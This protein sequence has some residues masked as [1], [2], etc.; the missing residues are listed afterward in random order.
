[1]NIKLKK[2]IEEN[3]LI[4][5][6]KSTNVYEIEGAGLF[7]LI[8]AKD[9]KLIDKEFVFKLS[10]EDK[11]AIENGDVT[12]ALFQFGGKYYYTPINKEKYI[13]TKKLG[14]SL[15][16]FKYLGKA[17]Q[18]LDLDFCH[19]GV[20]TEYE[21]MNGTHLAKDW[22]KKAKFLGQKS[23]GICDE[24]TLGGTLPFQTACKEKEIK[25][26]LGETVT[27]QYDNEE[28]FK[29]KLYV[30]NT[31]GWRNLLRINKAINVDNDGFID[32]NEFLKYGEGLILVFFRESVIVSVD[33]IQGRK[34]IKSYK[35]HFDDVYY[36]IDSVRYLDASYD[37]RQ[38]N[39][40]S[41]YFNEYSDLLEPVLINDSYYV[42]KEEF[43]TKRII[44]EID[45][46]A[47]P[48][49]ND[50]HYKTLDE[51]VEILND[52]F[53]PEKTFLNG[54]TYEDIL[55]LM[56]LNTQNIADKCNFTI[57]TGHHKL[58]RFESG[59][60]NLELFFELLE[61][62]LQKKVVEKNKNLDAYIKRLDIETDVIVNAGFVDYFL[63]LWDIVKW[64]K[65]SGIYV[66][67]ARGS[68]GG[69]LIAFLL[70]VITVDPIEHDL[71][72]ERFINK[73][74]VSGE[75][76]KAADALPDIDVDF[77]SF[78]RDDIKR[79]LEQKYG[80]DYVCSIGSYTRLKLKGSI[81]D[82]CRVDGMSFTF[83]NFITSRIKDKNNIQFEWQDI[84]KFAQEDK[85]LY[86]FIQKNMGLVNNMKFTINQA[87]TTSIHASAVIIVPKEDSE[88]NPMTIYDWM[89][90][91]KIVEKGVEF[92]VSEWEGKY[93]DKA[94]FLKEDILALSQL[95]KFKNILRLIKK[96]HG[97]DIVLEDIDM[98]V[99]GVYKIFQRGFNEEIFQFNSHGLKKYSRLIKPDCLEDLIAMNALFRPGPMKSN[100][101][102]D[103]ALIKHGKK[104]PEFDYMLKDVTKNTH[105][106]YVYQEQI[107]KAV[108]VLGNLTLTE[109]DEIRTVMKKF[110]KKKML[111]YEEKFIAGAKQNGCKPEEAANIWRKL[112]RFSG[113]GFN[114]SHSAAYAIMAYWCQWLKFHYPSE[115]YTVCFNFIRKDRGELEVPQ[116]I[117]EIRKRKIDLTIE[118]PNVNKSLNEFTLEGNNI[119]WSL[120]KI[121]GLGPSGTLNILKE[122][123]EN[124][125]FA[126]LEDFIERMKGKRVNAEKL[127]VAGAFDQL[128]NIK[129]LRDRK[130]LLERFASKAK[131]DLPE[132]YSKPKYNKSYNWVLL[133]RE[134]T[135]FGDINYESIV[136]KKNERLA[137]YYMEPNVFLDGDR[138][139][140]KALIAGKLVELYRRQSRRGEFAQLSLL[141]NNEI[142]Y[143]TMWSDVWEKNATR[144]DEIKKSGGLIAISGKVKFDDYKGV[145][146]LFTD[147]YE[148]KIIEL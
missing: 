107:M 44:N 79:Y 51:S 103:F 106:L 140:Q 70:D 130:N 82:F 39:A 95:D 54:L 135:G 97:V 32:K 80:R 88:G 13:E 11:K 47:R 75:R 89:P 73:T 111:T 52:L 83:A 112:E 30:V 85:H 63:I 132:E 4:V 17:R 62:G 14:V 27:I 96:N 124:G 94:G 35:T 110:D 143:C 12:N 28:K 123:R 64:A 23:L 109:S 48:V 18:D 29:V 58:P 93:I 116:L 141:C 133:Q 1:M 90:V 15:N 136:A 138:D 126:S 99:K 45:R 122:R 101:H 146:V 46:Q 42:D 8:E 22:V 100:A 105:G 33:K 37:K 119:Y 72:F 65:E 20:H 120:S 69:S 43:L 92:L 36:Q 57:D 66:G 104:K 25:P 113:Y 71:L 16:D 87:K 121:K 9:G 76:A 118:L 86:D 129:L 10:K 127:I 142:L 125:K 78:H 115:F 144:L 137:K 19:L 34:I 3:R 55:P 31:K 26:I 40:L 91:K 134:L 41:R 2:W 84:F 145:N 67:N 38:L 21:L 98:N 6:E 74:R 148:T 102:I 131:K 53:N 139:Y 128:E 108:H 50:Q 81:K 117:N 5:T 77:E 61:N 68:V 114:R 49:S 147:E 60:D 7:Y 24:N 59:K 56:L